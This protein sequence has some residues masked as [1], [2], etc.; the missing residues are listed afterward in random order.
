M[1]CLSF[2][3]AGGIDVVKVESILP[4]GSGDDVIISEAEK[5]GRVVITQDAGFGKS[6]FTGAIR[7]TG[8]IYIYPG[9]V[10]SALIIEILNHL[11][12]QS[13]SVE[14]PFIVVAQKK[15]EHIKIRTRNLFYQ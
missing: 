7:K 9:H 4:K 12:N 3:M 2:Y 14:L 11:F 15:H 8:I 1:P 10:G 13:L 6:Q 5:N